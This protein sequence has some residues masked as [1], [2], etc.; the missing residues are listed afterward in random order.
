MGVHLVIADS[1]EAA[2]TQADPGGLGVA[3]EVHGSLLQHIT[4]E[5]GDHGVEGR[6]VAVG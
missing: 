2:Q 4:A 1:P 3:E 5:P 6:A